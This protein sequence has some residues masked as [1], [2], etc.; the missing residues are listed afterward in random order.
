MPRKAAGLSAR[1]VQTLADPGYHADGGGLYLQ[2]TKTG[3]KTW[4]YRF[5]LRECRRDM[6]LGG[7]PTLSLAEAREKAAAARKRALAGQ[8]PIE[9]R[10]TF[11]EESPAPIQ[12]F[13]TAAQALIETKRPAWKNEK[14]A[15]QPQAP[16]R[17]PLVSASHS[18]RTFG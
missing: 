5:S 2:V 14:H 11:D 9:A 16:G 17:L 6:G 8:D 3:A 15:A 4:V 12:T 10:K 18:A 7:F 13:R 1:R